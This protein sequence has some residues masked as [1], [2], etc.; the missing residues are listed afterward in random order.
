MKRVIEELNRKI[1]LETKSNMT[2]EQEYYISGLSDALEIVKKYNNQYVIGHIYYVIVFDKQDN[3][4]IKRMKL[5]RINQK[6]KTSY[7]F[8]YDIEENPHCDLVLYNT[9]SLKIRVHKTLEEAEKHK[10]I[11]VV[12]RLEYKQRRFY[13]E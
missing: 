3:A 9:N 12:S 4:D 7:C 8:S 1:S 5:Y 6:S 10:S 11:A 13:R 2:P